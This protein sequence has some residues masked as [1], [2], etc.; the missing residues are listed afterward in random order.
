MRNALLIYNPQAGGNRL[1]PPDSILTHLESGKI[2]AQ[3]FILEG[4]GDEQRLLNA[5]TGSRFDLAV[6]SGGDGT[7]NFVANILLKNHLQLPIGIIPSGTSNDLARNLKIPPN[8]KKAVDLIAAG[9]T[10]LIDVGLIN[11]RTYFLSSCAGGLF[12]DVSYQTEGELKR[13][14]GPLAYYL[15]GVQELSRINPFRLT[16]KTK[17]TTIEEEVLLFFILNGPHVAGLTDL[18]KEAKP[19]DGWLRLVMIKNCDPIGLTGIFLNILGRFSLKNNNKVRIETASEF[20]LSSDREIVLSIDGEKSGTLP[21][22]L[23]VAT[24]KLTVFSALK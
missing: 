24:R 12:T 10:C 21:A 13:S 17:S 2:R 1:N 5:L 4:L 18:V 16:V 14:I 8:Y 6:I 19:N 9:K 11:K 23:T 3:T 15:K 22:A 20:E 7:I